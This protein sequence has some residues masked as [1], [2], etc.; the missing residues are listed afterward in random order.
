[1]VYVQKNF[2]I[3][4]DGIL[5]PIWPAFTLIL[6]Q[7]LSQ[8]TCSL[9]HSSAVLPFSL[10]RNDT[11]ARPSSASNDAHSVY[12]A[13]AAAIAVCFLY[14]VTNVATKIELLI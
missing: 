1:M 5:P 6:L 8:L 10:S 13:F 11:H 7:L 14:R 12:P 3:F 9:A 2:K 4:Y